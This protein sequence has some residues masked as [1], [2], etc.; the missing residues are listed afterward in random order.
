MQSSI[1][2]MSKENPLAPCKLI[3][4]LN[5]QVIKC[6]R[7]STRF[8]LYNNLMVFTMYFISFYLFQF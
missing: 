2:Q 6:A 4:Y 7:F 3:I 1:Q 8:E 5:K